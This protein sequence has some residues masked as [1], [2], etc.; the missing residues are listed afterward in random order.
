M[1]LP[2]VW[3]AV[4]CRAPVEF[5]TALGATQTSERASS[6]TAPALNGFAHPDGWYVAAA[7]GWNFSQALV[8]DAALAM[9][10][11]GARVVACY[12]HDGT[13]SSGASEWADGALVWK[14]AYSLENDGPRVEANGTL[15]P[16]LVG[17]FSIES[18]WEFPIELAGAR[19]SYDREK[20]VLGDLLHFE[21]PKP[22]VPSRRPLVLGAIVIG[23][24][25]AASV[26]D[27]TVSSMRISRRSAATLG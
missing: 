16:E 19:V 14:R 24:A 27:G 6:S 5:A 9:L 15:P 2:H 21:A 3:I 23:A 11:K 20:D 1:S 4:H 10:S 26:W 7:N 12:G 13:M 18:S 25:I 22:P 8:E 17:E